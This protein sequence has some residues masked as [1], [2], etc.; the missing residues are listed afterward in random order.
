MKCLADS[1]NNRSQESDS[2]GNLHDRRRCHSAKT[3]N[4]K[5]QQP[6]PDV[7]PPL[8][9]RCETIHSNSSPTSP[10]VSH[11]KPDQQ[12]STFS[13]FSTSAFSS[14]SKSGPSTPSQTRSS[15][16]PVSPHTNEPFSQ[17]SRNSY[18]EE[19][20]RLRRERRL[21]KHF[22]RR[23]VKEFKELRV[24]ESLVREREME[25]GIRPRGDVKGQYE[26]IENIDMEKEYMPDGWWSIPGILD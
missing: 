26:Y 21:N 25:M 2:T 15:S 11:S 1:S 4:A 17:E 6:P 8:G 24:R 16:P 10:S 20:R 3:D 23:L 12:P 13:S 5:T 7:L 14:V 9:Q 18:D 19:R 22:R